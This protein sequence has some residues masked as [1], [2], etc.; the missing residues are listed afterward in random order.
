[1][2]VPKPI[3]KL[4]NLNLLQTDLAAY[5]LEAVGV[6][7]SEHDAPEIPINVDDI[8]QCQYIAR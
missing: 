4:K 6:D 5:I 2:S 7:I 8:P 1:M 3:D